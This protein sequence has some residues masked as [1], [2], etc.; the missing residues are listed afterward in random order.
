MDDRTPLLGR[1]L[2]SSVLFRR[3]PA[4]PAPP[5]GDGPDADPTLGGTSPGVAL[6]VT[7]A[8]RGMRA[9]PSVV[10]HGY[11]SILGHP[12]TFPLLFP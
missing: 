9:V 4:S 8:A 3:G 2:I 6:D 7:P 5:T 12:T 1:P 11:L 10:Y